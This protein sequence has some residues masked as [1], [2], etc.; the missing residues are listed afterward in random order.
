MT[1]RVID[2]HDDLA[3]LIAWADSAETEDEREH[4]GLLIARHGFDAVRAA[5]FP[6]IE[7]GVGC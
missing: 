2:V 7:M 6:E 5:A 1:T 4:R 3:D